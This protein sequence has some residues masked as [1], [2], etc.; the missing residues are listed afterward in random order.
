MKT[1][2]LTVAAAV[3]ML[4]ACGEKWLDV[5]SKSSVLEAD[6]YVS[7]ERLFTG[8]VAAYD[9]LQWFDYFGQY[10]ALNMVSDI[11]ADDVYCGGS[12]EG[13]QPVLVKTH[14]YTLTPNDVPNQI[15]T[16]AYSGINRANIVLAK[17]PN[18]EMDSALKN[19]YIAECMILKAFYW[20]VLWH[21]WGNIPYYDENLTADQSYSAE[22]MKAD[23]VY[24]NVIKLIEDAI[25]M[26]ALPMKVGAGEEGRVTTAMAYMLYTEMVMYQNDQSRYSTALNYMKEIISSGKYSLVSDF[27]KIFLEEGEWNSESIFEINYESEGGV[28]DWG[29]ANGTGGS[30]Y[31]VLIGIPGGTDVYQDGWGF[32]PVRVQTFEMFEEGDTRRD[33]TIFDYRDKIDWGTA[34]WQATGLFLNKY[35]ARKG[36]NH[37]YV[38]SDNLN[39]GNNQRVYRYSETLLNAAEL[40]E[41]LGQ[42]GQS[43]L[44][45]VRSRAGVESVDCTIESVL[46]ERHLEF[47][48]EGKRYWDLVRTG[49]AATVLTAASHEYRSNNW[50]ESKKYWPIP[51]SEIDRSI[52]TLTQNPY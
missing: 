22:Q 9:P 5:P 14:Y 8:V 31:P 44:D 37:G 20:N 47:V 46:Q 25:A 24:A 42:D 13:D 32:E 11:M 38:A 30:V 33:A 45:E 2:I 36:G 35:I 6:Y 17:A 21:F 3:L 52:T 18:V 29:W 19:R 7:Q 51:Q 50:T 41:R 39:Y 49:N 28:R 23:D 1:K 40:S 15:W 10:D 12:S 4:S 27:G 26:K 43:Y 34:R 16:V 48:G